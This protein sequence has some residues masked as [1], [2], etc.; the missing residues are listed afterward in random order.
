MSTDGTSCDALGKTKHSQALNDATDDDV[1]DSPSPPN[2]ELLEKELEKEYGIP[3]TTKKEE[4]K[5]W[6]NF[7]EKKTD[8]K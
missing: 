6:G 4:P 3:P 1:F 8:K 5:K 7:N 2:K